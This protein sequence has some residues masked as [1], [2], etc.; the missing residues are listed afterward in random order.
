MKKKFVSPSGIIVSTVKLPYAKYYET[1]IFNQ[2]GVE[3]F[4]RI[5]R[6]MESALKWH[7]YYVQQNSK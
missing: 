3:I 5:Y 7:E 6:T 4:C 2:A 1:I